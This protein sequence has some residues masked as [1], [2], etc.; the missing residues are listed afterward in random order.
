MFSKFLL[1]FKVKNINNYNI[2][3]KLIELSLV[4]NKM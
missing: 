3:L 1:K 2:L 4:L